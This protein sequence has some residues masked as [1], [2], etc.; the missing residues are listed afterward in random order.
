MKFSFFKTVRMH[1]LLLVL[2]SILPALGIIIY[3]GIERSTHAIDMARSEALRVV[4]DLAHDHEGAV[5]STRQFLMT[6]AKVP[7]IR[8]LQKG[9]SNQLLE[10]LQKQNLLYGNIFV[11]NAQ[12]ILV[13]SS[14]APLSPAPISLASG[15]FFQD[16]VRT[17]DFSVG[18]YAVCP[19]L[20]R[21]V[22][23]FAYPLLDTGNRFIGAVA[24]SLDLAR[25]ARIFFIDRLSQGSTLTFCDRKGTLLFRNPPAQDNKTAKT[26]RPEI[27]SLMSIQPK[28]GIF[29]YIGQDGVRRLNAYEKF[30]LSTMSPPYLFMRVSI[31]EKK[32]LLPAKKFIIVNVMLLGGAFAIA[33]IS[34][35]FLGNT[36]IVKR[37]N[38]L[39]EASR[40]LGQGDLKTRTGLDYKNDELGH[41]ARVF[42]EM[43]EALEIKNAEREKAEKAIQSERQRFQTLADNAPFGMILID[44]MWTFTYLNPRFKELFGYDLPDIPNGKTWLQKAFPNPGYRRDVF[45]NWKNDFKEDQPGQKRSK[46]YTVTSKEGLQKETSFTSVMLNTGEIVM[47]CEDITE[48]KR[49]EKALQ[50]SEAKYRN[51]VEN[52]LVGICIIQDDLL[53]FV[54][55]GFCEIFG[56]DCEEIVDKKHPLFIVHPEDKKRVQENIE[57]RVGGEIEILEY[58]FRA[59]RKDG[60]AITIKSFGSSMVYKGRRAATGVLLDITREKTLETQLHQAQKMEAIG[61]LAGGVAHDFNNLLMTILGYTALMLLETDPEDPNYEKLKIIERQVQSGAELTRQLLGFARRGR[62]EIKTTDLNKLLVRSSELFGRTKKEISIHKKLEKDLW[63]V[64]VDRGQMEQVLLNLFV[65][66][67]QAMPGGGELYLETGNILVDDSQAQFLAIKP[68]NYVKVSITDNGLGMDEATRQRIFEPFFT[69]KEMG[70]GTGLG[71]ASAYGVI[72]NH[73]GTINVYSEKMKGT[74]FSLYLPAS[75]KTVIEEKESSDTLLTGTET[76][77]LVDD[78]EEILHVG[79]ALLQRLGYTVLLAKSGEE[80]LVVYQKNKERIDLVILDMVMPVMS[81]GEVYKMLKGLNPLLKAILSSGYS[82]NGQAARI[83]EDG[84]NGFIQKPFHVVELSK[85]IR[86]VLG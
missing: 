77:L 55:K 21:P 15:K 69:T 67:W 60:K 39:V 52:S 43:A 63:T 6:L 36:I 10:E 30:H 20:S 84:C 28:E 47:S 12:G 80:A 22:L 81:G 51:V 27:F 35:W 13:S 11:T 44:K 75:G 82:L 79:K 23:H 70:R 25:Y 76:I 38:K 18:E 48:Q 66:A 24:V 78:Q 2:I 32:A 49:V 8:N 14:A 45:A 7:E 16:V 73:G 31:P 59:F 33:L 54:N 68:G 26:E 19:A 9:G 37:L 3:S 53:R 34:A 50:E 5:E 65:N 74:T 71:L 58:E 41:L 86:E 42:D 29:P 17:K 4:Q 56:Y 83:M 40:R 62:Y 1:L 85:K 57:K 46:I 64:E 61:T 72:K